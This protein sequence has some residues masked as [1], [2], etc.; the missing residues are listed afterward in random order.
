MIISELFSTQISVLNAATQKMRSGV[1]PPLWAVQALWSV[2]PD[3]RVGQQR[4]GVEGEISGEITEGVLVREQ[5]LEA[6]SC[7]KA[8]L[9]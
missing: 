9:Y 6:T 5:L 3:L 7:R 1:M 4:G 8:S 2:F